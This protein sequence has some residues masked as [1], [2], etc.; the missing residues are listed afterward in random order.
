MMLK[1]KG[2]EKKVSSVKCFYVHHMEPVSVQMWYKKPFA[3]FSNTVE[4]CLSLMSD[5]IM[6]YFL[7]SQNG[8]E[9]HFQI[10]SD[11]Y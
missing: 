6:T 5:Y 7:E 11:L 4:S 8:A 1:G 9:N 3:N 10:Q 2:K